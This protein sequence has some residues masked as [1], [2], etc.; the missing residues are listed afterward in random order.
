MGTFCGDSHENPWKKELPTTCRFR[1]ERAAVLPIFNVMTRRLPFKDLMGLAAIPAMYRS[2]RI[3]ARV[4]FLKRSRAMA[5][6]K[7][8]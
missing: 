2:N 8:Q 3:V 7:S 4:Q 1:P 5:E 6:W